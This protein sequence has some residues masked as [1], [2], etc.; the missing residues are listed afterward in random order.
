MRRAKEIHLVNISFI[1]MLAGALGATIILFIIVPKV[2]FADLERLKSID[3]L[4]INKSNLDSVIADLQSVVPAND[5]Q[6]LINSSASLQASIETLKKNVADIQN[7]LSV[8]TQQYNNVAQKY[9]R[10]MATI[11]NLE[12]QLKAAPSADQYK[13]MAAELEAAKKRIAN[14]MASQKTKT[15]VTAT[16]PQPITAAKPDATPGKGDAVFGIDPPLTIMINWDDRKD[17]VHLYMREAGTNN[18]VFYQTKRRRAAFGTWDNSLKKLTS[19]PFEAIIQKEALV[20]GKYEIYAQPDKAEKGSVD[21]SGFI[22]MKLVDKPIKKYNIKTQ[23]ISVSKPPYSHNSG[24]TMLGV[25]TITSDDIIW[26]PK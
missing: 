23:N 7:Q 22:A 13:K 12:S 26:E 24:D 10:A 18:W 9:D 4:S 8:K 6:D 14:P 21:V 5:Y 2:S 3:S 25:L 15:P 17:R 19:K 1:D 20:P 16:S 11:R